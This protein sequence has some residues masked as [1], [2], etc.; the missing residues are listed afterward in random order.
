MWAVGDWWAFGEH[1]Y[2]ERA[3]IVKSAEWEGPAFQTCVDAATVCR[4]F[5]STSRDVVRWRAVLMI[6]ERQCPHPRCICW[7]CG[8]FHNAADHDAIA[9]HVVI[10]VVR[11]ARGALTIRWRTTRATGPR[12]RQGGWVREFNREF[13]WAR[14]PR[15]RSYGKRTSTRSQLDTTYT[16]GTTHTW[17]THTWA[18]HTLATT[19]YRS[20]SPC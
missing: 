19:S 10:V 18:T 3:A 8:S 14:V 4:R 13:S 17:G 20:T 9:E 12:V 5:E 11:F 16:I 1:R 7:R 6:H 15:S 2:G